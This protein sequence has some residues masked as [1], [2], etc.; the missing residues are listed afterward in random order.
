MPTVNPSSFPRAVEKYYSPAELALLSSLCA[1]VIIQKMK[2]GEFGDGWFNAGSDKRPDY[3][4]PASG[5]N[6]WV[7]R[8]R[9]IFSELS[10]EYP[11]GIAART[12]GE[13]RRKVALR[14]LVPV[15]TGG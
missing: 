4:I 9:G 2:A 3:R 12:P 13:L 1:K 7:D 15:V 6:G 14:P 10:G 5:F 11:P 8:R